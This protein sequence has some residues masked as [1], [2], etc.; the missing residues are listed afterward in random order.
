[1]LSIPWTEDVCQRITCKEQIFITCHVR[2]ATCDVRATCYV[3]GAAT[4]Y[5]L[6][7]VRCAT[8]A[9]RQLGTGSRKLEA[10]SGTPVAA[11]RCLEELMRRIMAIVGVLF[12]GGLTYAQQANPRITRIEFAPVTVEEGGGVFVT[13]VG[14][15]RCSYTLD[16]GDGTT[17]KRSAELP[18]R[19]RHVF[20][21]DGEYLVVATPE[22]PCE[23]G[24]R[25]KLDV[26]A[27]NR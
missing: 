6:R 1:M 8:C 10:E 15:G 22:A 21:G 13:L 5:V 19:L 9:L 7:D 25:A 12:F 26:R 20:A 14:S 3:L 4:C 27:V 23:G 18:D 24:A 16:F 17:D 11:R 2:G